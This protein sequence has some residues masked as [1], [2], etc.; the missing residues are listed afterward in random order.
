MGDPLEANDSP[1]SVEFE[2]RKSSFFLCFSLILLR[3]LN[4]C[5]NCD[6]KG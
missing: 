6:F 4:N 3:A 2:R 1:T 5:H